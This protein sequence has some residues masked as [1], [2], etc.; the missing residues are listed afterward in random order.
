[1]RHLAGV[2]RQRGPYTYT[3]RACDI[4][5]T[6]DPVRRRWDGAIPAAYNTHQLLDMYI[7]Q[8]H[9]DTQIKYRPVY[10]SG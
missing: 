5:R 3:Q 4:A 10:V 7:C 8:V 6:R 9:S 2:S 1:M